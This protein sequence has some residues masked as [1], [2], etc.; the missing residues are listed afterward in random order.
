MKKTS[1]ILLILAITHCY[2]SAQT[3]DSNFGMPGSLVLFDG[4][5]RPGATGCDFNNRHD[6]AY[7]TLHLSNGKILLAGHSSGQDGTDFALVRLLPNGRYDLDAGQEGQ[8]RID[9]GYLNDSCLV[10]ALSPDEKILMGGCVTLPGQNGYV[11]LLVKVDTDGQP[12]TG[13]GNGGQV[14]L[15]WP[16]DNEMVTKIIPLP[17]GKTLIAGNAYYGP[18]IHFPDS[19]ALFI[20]R[21]LPDGQMDESFGEN[22]VVFQRFNQTCSISLLADMAVDGEERIVVTG[23]LYGSYPGD[24]DGSA[25]CNLPYV[26]VSRFISDGQPDPDFGNEGIVFLPNTPGWANAIHVE[27]DGKIVLAGVHARSSLDLYAFASRLL[28][29]GAPDVSFGDDGRYETYIFSLLSSPPGFRGI[30][31]TNAGYYLSYWNQLYSDPSPAG[32]VRLTENGE[33]DNTFGPA[34]SSSGIGFSLNN[35]LQTP[36]NIEHLS[37]TDSESIFLTGTYRLLNNQNMM[38]GKLNFGP[39][40]SIETPA[41]QIMK[42]FPNPVQNNKIYMDFSGT[43]QTGPSVIQWLDLFGRVAYRQMIILTEGINELELPDLPPGTY[44]LE[45]SGRDSIKVTKVIIQK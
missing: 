32:L 9:L 6:R 35:W 41:T 13:F 18:S 19:S 45:V 42:V 8:I 21:L 15:E 23:G 2:L 34:Q 31:R 25:S 39:V 40:A 4:T 1:T 17:N 36:V 3:P 22:G 28:P 38:I 24:I 7:S 33:L 43:T 27:N 29:N 44:A 30:L 12:D 11:N 16:S 5:D 26:P 14:V 10:A 37:V 20:A